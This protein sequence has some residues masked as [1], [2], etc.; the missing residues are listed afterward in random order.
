WKLHFVA[1][2]RAGLHRE[3][4]RIERALG[5]P[6]GAGLDVGERFAALQR[7]LLLRQ[8]ERFG[9]AGVPPDLPGGAYFDAQARFASFLR[10]DLE[11]GCGV[12]G[13]GWRLLPRRGRA[14]GGGADEDPGGAGDAHRRIEELPRLIAFDPAL[15]DR[16]TWTQ[17][18]IAENLKRTRAR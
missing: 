1:D 17:E 13:G 4:G 2:V 18:Q 11:G 9:F 7:N 3:M 6:L 12:T 14:S 10:S 15:Y 8:R 5:L 16:P